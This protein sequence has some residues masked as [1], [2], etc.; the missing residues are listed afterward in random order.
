M[1][2]KLL[3]LRLLIHCECCCNCHIPAR[4]ETRSRCSRRAGLQRVAV[5]G[6]AHWSEVQAGTSSGMIDVG[7]TCLTWAA[8]YSFAGSYT[9]A[10][11]PVAKHQGWRPLSATGR[12]EEQTHPLRW[13][14]SRALLG[15]RG[16]RPFSST[17]PP[18]SYSGR[19]SCPGPRRLQ[20][21]ARGTAVRLIQLAAS[22]GPPRRAAPEGRALWAKP[23]PEVV[24]RWLAP[25]GYDDT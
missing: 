12:D 11:S 20:P 8:C 25:Q 21:G 4:R 19:H 3:R 1:S 24:V 18:A 22:V 13:V 6:C 17:V 23:A 5:R 10:T 7:S 16:S 9:G 2:F 14:R 15:D